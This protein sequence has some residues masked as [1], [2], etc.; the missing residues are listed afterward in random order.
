MTIP[1]K[2]L[3]IESLE[4]KLS[5]AYLENREVY[6][7]PFKKIDNCTFIESYINYFNKVRK[8]EVT[9]R[10]IRSFL[11]DIRTYQ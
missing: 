4:D 1:S 5:K 11:A 7:N 10:V 2:E 3:L 8:E 9:Y 6:G